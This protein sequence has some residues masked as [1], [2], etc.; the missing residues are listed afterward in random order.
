M[1]HKLQPGTLAYV[2]HESPQANLV[3]ST[4]IL[5]AAVDGRLHP[6]VIMEIIQGSVYDDNG[7]VVCNL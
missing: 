4:H 3:R 6:G 7:N 1:T 5:D 2:L